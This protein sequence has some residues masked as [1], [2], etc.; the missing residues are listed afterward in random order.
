MKAS[1]VIC[2]LALAAVSTSGFAEIRS[3]TF[4]G[5]VTESLP[6]A[7]MG[8]K[9]TGTFTYDTLATPY[10]QGGDQAGPGYGDAAYFAK[11]SL[12]MTVNG[13]TLSAVTPIIYVVNNFGGNVE[14]AISVSGE[15]FTLNGTLFPE[16]NF[17]FYLGSGP[18][19]TDV[20]RATAL[21]QTIP[22]ERYEGAN[23]GWVLVDRS[24]TGTVLVFRI[25]RVVPR[26]VDATAPS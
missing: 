15:V 1:S 7:L 18:G 24:Q 9:L 3:F 25:D 8:T 14:D 13:H 11:G 19:K 23:F 6:M 21:P 2:S 10:Y 16:S 20:L 17:G 22:A 4:T 12:T 5:T 26:T